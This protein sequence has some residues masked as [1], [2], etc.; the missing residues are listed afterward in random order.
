[1]SPGLSWSRSQNRSCAY[2]RTG[3]L[4]TGRR[5]MAACCRDERERSAAALRRRAS[6]SACFCGES[7]PTLSSALPTS[8]TP[9]HRPD[10]LVRIMHRSG[11]DLVAFSHQPGCGRL[12]EEA[13]V[14]FD[15]TVHLPL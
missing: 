8:A 4:P 11:K 9:H 14:V 12:L 15:V 2:E 1:M 6:S 10:L 3:G 5:S 7:C 13:G